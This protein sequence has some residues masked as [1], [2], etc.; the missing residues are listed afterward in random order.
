VDYKRTTER[1]AL[2][3]T[4]L[5]RRDWLAIQLQLLLFGRR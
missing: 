4:C 1:F 2:M 3:V 5:T